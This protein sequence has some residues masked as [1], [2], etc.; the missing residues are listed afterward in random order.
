M[1]IERAESG[2]PGPEHIAE[3]LDIALIER[4]RT[5]TNQATR[6]FE[7]F[8]YATA[9]Q[10]VEES[11]WQ[12]CDHY[13]ELVKLRSYSDEDTPGRRSAFTSTL[14]MTPFAFPEI[15]RVACP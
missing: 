10:V 12:F 8:D 11:F 3:P 13:L 6:A 7:A 2:M 4:L 14:S 15:M 9:L 1:Q 5:V